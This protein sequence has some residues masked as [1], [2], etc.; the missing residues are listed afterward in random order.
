MDI[1]ETAPRTK[2]GEHEIVFTMELH[3]NH[4]FHLRSAFEGR[5]LWELVKVLK[6][7]D[8]AKVL[9]E[10]HPQFLFEYDCVEDVEGIFRSVSTPFM[11][12]ISKDRT[13][14]EGSDGYV[15][16]EGNKL[17]PPF[18]P[19]FFSPYMF[20]RENILKIY[21]ENRLVY[22]WGDSPNAVMGYLSEEVYVEVPELKEYNKRELSDFI[23][24]LRT[25]RPALD[26]IQ[27]NS[28]L[29]SGLEKIA[30][31]HVLDALADAK[32]YQNDSG[33]CARAPLKSAY[34]EPIHTQTSPELTRRLADS[35][36]AL[37]LE[38]LSEIGG[39]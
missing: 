36:V 28:D 5:R 34:E 21:S 38:Y 3:N 23:G 12:H 1:T 27:K 31:F 29:M 18:L 9:A 15:V 37:C 8:R 25:E 11:G 30:R 32:W 19:I 39:L 6:D 17:L 13:I 20:V 4:D 22:L 26:D 24:K 14:K 35:A 16:Y 2:D 10:R 33:L 7:Q